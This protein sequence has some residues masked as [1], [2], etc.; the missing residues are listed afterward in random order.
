MS[1]LENTSKNKNPYENFDYNTYQQNGYNYWETNTNKDT[2][3]Q[4][5]EQVN[6]PKK[7][8]VSFDDILKNMNVVVNNQGVLQYMLPK[9]DTFTQ[10]QSYNSYNQN[11]YQQQYN[12]QNRTPT[13]QYQQPI[14]VYK[15]PV[16]NTKIQGEPIDPSLKHSYIYNK[17]FSDYND[18]NANQGPE[19]RVPKTK[20][21]YYQMLLDDKIKAEEE[22]RRIELI[23]PKT[24]LFSSGGHYNVYQPPQTIKPS[25]NNLRMMSFH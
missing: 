14:Q 15:E 2:I 10:E 11:P 13:Q 7:K 25:K 19:I 1:E 3:K 23:K 6:K 20:E 24:M 22:R 4:D 5:N 18:P 8:K 12:T 9:R 16:N 21:E 17:Y